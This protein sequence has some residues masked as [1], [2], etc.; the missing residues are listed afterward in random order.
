MDSSP[1]PLHNSIDSSLN[2]SS[3][4]LKNSQ[5][6]QS[7]ENNKVLSW[8]VPILPPYIN[9]YVTI[10]NIT[11]FML[12]AIG[13]TIVILVVARIKDMHSNINLYL[14]NLSVADLFVLFVCQPTA[15]VEFFARERWI[16]G[17]ELCE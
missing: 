6:T 15:L 10:L 11:I 4:W 1:R 16:L 3:V 12:G 14:V 17:K 2:S 13:N 5:V 9:I 8:D 7:L